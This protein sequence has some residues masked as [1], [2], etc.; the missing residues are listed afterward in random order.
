MH[1]TEG[2]Y[3]LFSSVSLFYAVNIRL[4]VFRE[5]CMASRAARLVR[6]DCKRIF[7]SDISVAIWA[8][9]LSDIFR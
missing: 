1:R 2:C 3:D 8:T 5:G 7:T 9:A 4:G 6:F